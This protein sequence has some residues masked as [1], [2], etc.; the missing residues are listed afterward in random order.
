MA[1]IREM[2]VFSA[3]KI[4]VPEELPTILKELSKDVIVNNPQNVIAFAKEHFKKK[5][6]QQGYTEQELQ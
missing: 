5:L 3:D 6:L 1:D 4:N 2:R